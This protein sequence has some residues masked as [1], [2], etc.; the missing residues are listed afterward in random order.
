MLKGGFIVSSLTETGSVFGVF[1]Q[2]FL[3]FHNSA[4]NK[5][6]LEGSGNPSLHTK[7]ANE[8]L[9]AVGQRKKHWHDRVPGMTP[10]A[11]SLGGRGGRGAAETAGAPG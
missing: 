3:P 4:M 5:A 1:F 10:P 9:N 2:K 7:T 11:T 8:S 6:S